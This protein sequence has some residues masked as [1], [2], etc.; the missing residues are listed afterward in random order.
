M[1]SLAEYYSSSLVGFFSYSRDDDEG[2][3]GALSALRDAIQ[4]ELSAQ[5]GRSQSN[6]QIWQ[7][8]AAIPVG[9]FW[10]ERI[11]LGISQ[12][13]FFIPIVTPRA[14][15]SKNCAFEFEAFLAREKE[16]GRTDLVFPLLYIPVPELQDEKIWRN[17]PVLNVVG[18]RQYFD[19]RNLRFAASGSPEVGA[20]VAKF[21]QNIANA[22][23]A[24]WE[25]PNERQQRQENEASR[26]AEQERQRTMAKIA[27]ERAIEEQRQREADEAARRAEETK[28][29]AQ[30]VADAQERE[31][32]QR[33]REEALAAQ[34]A[35]EDRAF[36]AAKRAGTIAAFDEFLAAHSDSAFAGEAKT[37]REALLGRQ[38]AH[39]RAMASDDFAVLR[40]FCKTYRSG[41]DVAEVKAR[42]QTLA[43]PPRWKPSRPALAMAAT[44]AAMVLVGGVIWRLNP[45]SP[46]KIADA[47]PVSPPVPANTAPATLAARPAP[48]PSVPAAPAKAASAQPAPIPPPAARPAP[49]E[50]PPA[51][52]VPAAPA[53]AA[54]AQP[55]P[56]IPPPP[57]APPLPKT[58]D[59]MPAWPA[60]PPTPKS[61]PSGPWTFCR[62]GGPPSADV[63]G[64]DYIPATLKVTGAPKG[65]RA[66][67]FSPDGQTLVSAGDDTVIHVWDAGTL[68]LIKNLTGHGAAVFSVAFSS[69]GKLLASASFDGTVRVWNAHT[70]APMPPFTAADDKGIV[71]QY[72]VAFQPVSDPQYVYSAG[73]DGNVWIWDLRK[74]GPPKKVLSHTA[75]G[76]PAVGSLSFAPNGSGSF[77][78]A[79]FDGTINFFDK[80]RTD[81]VSGFAG[82][83]LR[84]AYSPNS[85]WV[86]AAGAD[87][88]G[89]S[90][91][92]RVWNALTHALVRGFPAHRGHATSVAWSRD[93]M[94]LATGGGYLDPSIAL[95]DP[96][97]VGQSPLKVFPGHTAEVQ[98]EDK[99]IEAI[100]FHPNQKWLVSAGE[101]GTMRL[102]DISSGNE[103]LSVAA[104]ADGYLAYTPS[105]CF[106]GSV[107]AGKYLKF[108]YKDEQGR[109]R[110]RTDNSSLFAPTTAAL[111]PQ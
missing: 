12:S 76:D 90:I 105:G 32:E 84:L 98:S 16:L 21:C 67:A 51:N 93:G 36:T 74:P 35:E 96:Q 25:S 48:I 40:S 86:A 24:S 41:T 107:N 106:T 43:P 34:R 50:A 72:G 108:V 88:A 2:S 5:L 99:D 8:K 82:K 52:A 57:P 94:Q 14:F 80:D 59:A 27:A 77:V 65:F 6:F 66:I 71:K 63:V 87:A 38:E 89:K 33:R 56:P 81:P 10:E 70:F 30:A 47:I 39:D 29:R 78:T 100:A 46:P 20:E 42:L 79:N 60:P 61:A 83:V 69:D 45:P 101:D 103:L 54:L 64:G 13:V 73:G 53:K 91:G 95:W 28:R 1:S 9:T 17:D 85:A 62:S 19:W 4:W 58:A 49:A 7:D 31:V 22:L 55:A 68:K 111:L 104:F 15:K 23:R 92:M 102:W 11:K 75:K 18:T 110:E 26:L 44:V 109:E 37:L 3:R 97:S